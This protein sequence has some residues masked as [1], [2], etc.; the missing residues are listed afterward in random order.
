MIVAIKLFNQS[1]CYQQPLLLISAQKMSLLRSRSP[2]QTVLWFVAP[3]ELPLVYST[4]QTIVN[5]SEDLSYR[6]SCFILWLL[7]FSQYQ[8]SLVAGW[9][10]DKYKNLEELFVGLALTIAALVCVAIAY[11]PIVGLMFPEFAIQGLMETWINIGLFALSVCSVPIATIISCR[12][13]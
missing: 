3:I 8:T 9:L 12:V 6:L 2:V 5:M 10:L 11:T 1:S 7:L 4:S 13:L